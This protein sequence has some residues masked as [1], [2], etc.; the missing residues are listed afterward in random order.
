MSLSKCKK[1]GSEVNTHEKTC[2]VCG[3][4]INKR[5]IVHYLYAFAAIVLVLA[6][7]TQVYDFLNEKKKKNEK[8]VQASQASQ[9]ALTA[10][11]KLIEEAKRIAAEQAAASARLEREKQILHKK[12]E[13]SPELELLN[14]RWSP[15]YGSLVIAEGQVKNISGRKLEN[16]QAL[17]TWY[18]KD[19][20]MVTYNNSLIAYNPLMPGQISPFKVLDKHNSAM[21]RANIE[22]KYMFGKKIEVKY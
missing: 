20:K 5:P 1:C 18:D 6:I 11:L 8:Q 10:N 19:R 13:T 12:Q 14:W 4:P 2:S 17:V 22:F 16:V 7:S 9:A 21:E 3:A 15:Q